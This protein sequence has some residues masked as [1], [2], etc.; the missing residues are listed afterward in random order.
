MAQG[1]GLLNVAAA[2]QSPATASPVSISF[3]PQPPG[4]LLNSINNL[5]VTNAQA[6][7]DTFEVS[8]TPTRGGG[9]H[10]MTVSPASF[11]LSV[12]NTQTLL[13]TAASSQPLNETIE[14]YLTIQGANTNRSITVSYWGT[15]LRP[16]VNSGGVV[17]AASF[18]SGPISVAA[19]GLISIFGTQLANETAAAVSLPLPTSLGGVRVEIDG[20]DAPLLF[21]SPNQINA[22]VPVEVSGRSVATLTILL[23]GV[24]SSSTLLIVA[25]AAPGIFTASENGQGRGA[26]LRASDFSSVTEQ[27]PARAGEILS[28]FATGLGS[29]TP[30]VESGA[31]ASSSTLSVT[32]ITP[33][34]TLGGISVPVRFSSLAPSF[35]GLYQVNIEVPSGLVSGP[36]PLVITSNTVA[37]NS[38]TVQVGP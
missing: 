17:N 2:V 31:P 18:A 14:G 34:A 12:G 6:S 5:S 16:A 26:V 22:Q 32:R 20:N 28:V 23:N 27:R 4:T 30:S 13:V 19:G 11:S 3:G 25:Q 38:V 7:T 37:S 33:S 8:V 10:S 24:T 1:N 35:V 36:Q 21:V 9:R 29:V 15:F